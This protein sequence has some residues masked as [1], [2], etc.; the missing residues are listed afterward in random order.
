MRIVP[1]GARSWRLP[2]IGVVLTSIGLVLQFGALAII[3]LTIIVLMTFMAG[4]RYEREAATG[5]RNRVVD[6]FVG[7]SPF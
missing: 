2:L 4:S 3:P 7:Q 5:D 6:A 1:W